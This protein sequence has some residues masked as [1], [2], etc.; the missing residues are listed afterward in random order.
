MR[1]IIIGAGRGSRLMPTT[2]NAPK[3][4]AEIRGR[5]ILDWTVEAL[6]NGGCT[7][8]CFIGGY[9]VETVKRDYPDF[10]F[11][12]NVDWPNNNILASLMCAEDLMDRPFVTAYSDI[13]F[14]ADIVRGLVLSPDE[15]VLG[16]DTDWREH[17]RPRTQHP[18]HDAEKVITAEGRV[19]R[20]HRGIP[21]EE[22][23]GEF[24]GVARFDR[25]GARRLCDFYHRRKAEFWGKPY[26]E[27]ALFQRAYLIHLFQ[28]MIENGVLFGHVDTPGNYREIDT[29]EDMELA[30]THWRP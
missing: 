16:I 15:I 30:Q 21:Y 17:Y 4:Y 2:E 23:T 6:K 8:I 3:C 7:E 19:R 13:L 22:A 5:R 28:D 26:R 11:R 25:E 14:T 29:Q 27:A 20:V 9:R 24:I 1:A 10:T 18:P 12:E